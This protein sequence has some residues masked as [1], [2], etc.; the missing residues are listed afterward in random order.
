VPLLD[1]L[2]T[3]PLERFDRLE[4]SATD[5]FVAQ[6]PIALIEAGKS[7]GS[8]AWIA[9]ETQTIPGPSCQGKTPAPAPS[10]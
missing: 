8:V 7:G 10:I 3:F 5:G 2:A 4:T 9:V 1:L 6:I